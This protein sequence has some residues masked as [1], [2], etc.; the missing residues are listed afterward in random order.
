MQ[1]EKIMYVYALSSGL[2]MHAMRSPSWMIGEGERE[3]ECHRLPVL[4]AR[5]RHLASF[6]FA[7]ALS[8]ALAISLGC[9]VRR[10]RSVAISDVA[11]LTVKLFERE[12]MSRL[13]QRRERGDRPLLPRA[14]SLLSV[15]P[16]RPAGK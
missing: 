7:H 2:S 11:W 10:L 9:P 1:R 4:F 14:L 15:A 13:G 16:A 6:L 12:G 5:C 8:G 3:E